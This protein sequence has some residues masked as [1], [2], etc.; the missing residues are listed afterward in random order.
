[1]SSGVPFVTSSDDVR[2]D[3]SEDAAGY[4]T[5]YTSALFRKGTQLVLSSQC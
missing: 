4:S 1:M 5:A 3:V 2:G